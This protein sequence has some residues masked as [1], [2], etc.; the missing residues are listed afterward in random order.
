MNAILE[1]ANYKR[2]KERAFE[3]FEKAYL[4]RRNDIYFVFK[5]IA[6]FISKFGNIKANHGISMFMVS[7][8]AYIDMKAFSKNLQKKDNVFKFKNFFEEFTMSSIY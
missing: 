8:K 6:P 2:E 7:K 3:E 5:F 4:D 1:E